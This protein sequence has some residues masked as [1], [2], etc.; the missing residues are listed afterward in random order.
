MNNAYLQFARDFKNTDNDTKV[1]PYWV[2]Q[3]KLDNFDCRKS[4]DKTK[5]T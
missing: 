5:I 3:N 1:T 4:Y 2:S